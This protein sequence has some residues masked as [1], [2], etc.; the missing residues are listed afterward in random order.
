M[1]R[2]YTYVDKTNTCIRNQ[3]PCIKY[4]VKLALNKTSRA[5]HFT[6]QAIHFQ[7]KLAYAKPT[8]YLILYITQL[9]TN[10]SILYKSVASQE[11]KI[12]S[13]LQK[14]MYL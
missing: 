2:V 6:Q 3:H 4:R 12:N 10:K 7:A 14:T 11:N 13:S 1:I 9:H 8:L 5:S